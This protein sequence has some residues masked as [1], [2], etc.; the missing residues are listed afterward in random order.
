MSAGGAWRQDVIGLREEEPPT[1]GEALLET[2]MVEGERCA[3]DSLTAARARAEEG[4]RRLGERHRRL[5]AEAYEVRK[6]ASLVTL[7][8][9]LADRVRRRHGL[10]ATAGERLLA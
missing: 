8:N 10:M 3:D 5:D 1:E 6:S 2:V 4:R 7:W 9:E